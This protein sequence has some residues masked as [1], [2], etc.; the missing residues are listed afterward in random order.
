MNHA[1]FLTL[2]LLFFSCQ[3]QTNSN[4][5]NNNN[6]TDTDQPAVME[7]KDPPSTKELG[8][9]SDNID[10]TPITLVPKT[11]TLQDG[12]TFSL[13]VP[14]GYAI[15]PV[16]E[17]LRRVRFFAKSPDDRLFV[18]GMHGLADNKKGKVFILENFNPATHRFDKITV[19]KDKLHNPNS[20]QFYTDQ[21]GQDWLYLAMTEQL[22]R[23]KYTSGE[24][25]PSSAPEVLMTFPSYGLSYKY[26]GW[27]L[28]RTIAFHKDKLYLSVGS[29]C[30]LCE[31][32]LDESMRATVLE[33]D[34]DGTNSAIFAYGVRN[35]VDIGWVENTF[36]AT[37]MGADH[38]GK[39]APD[40]LMYI[41]EKGKH[42][43]WPYCYEAGGIIKEEDPKDQSDNKV[44]NAVLKDTWERKNIECK[45]IPTGYTA[46]ESHA[47][48]LG[49]E[50]FPKNFQLPALRNYFLV[51]LHGSGKVSQARGYAIVRTKKNHKP[52]SV[53]SGFLKDG[54]RYGR[55]CDVI[56]R[57]DRS[58]FFTDDHIGV[59]YL[60]TKE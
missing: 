30:N 12:K 36:F 21:T 43:G 29:S 25:A 2:C 6:N 53:I 48:P 9:E 17:G 56:I 46:F 51:A 58:F 1:V 23:Y 20:V 22:V 37:N 55:P 16:A 40:D 33:M 35:A 19:W 8:F 10:K 3:Q 44:P 18:T 38:L 5:N 39:E 45:D 4:N 41:L 50:Y 13:N 32:R 59:V 14:E 42:Y 47:S 26:G 34:I 52:E 49:F 24:T 7:E 11:I 28:T 15:Y 60:V 54:E 31:E 57:D 27:H